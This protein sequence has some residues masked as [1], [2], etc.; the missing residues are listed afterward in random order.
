MVV[1]ISTYSFN[2]QHTGDPALSERYFRKGVQSLQVLNYVDALYYFSQAYKASPSSHY[3]ELSYLYL[4][5]SYALYSYAYGSRKGIFASIAF[6]NE[7]PF[8]YKVPRFIH[9]QREFIG[10]S[11]LL[12]QWYGTAKNIYAN[13]YGET[14]RVEYMI[15]FGYASSLEGSIEGYNYLKKL[16]Q[17]GVPR[18]YLDL[19]YMTM[20]FY[21]FNLGKYS[22]SVEYLSY[23]MNINTHL[24][25]DPHLLFR[26]GVSYYKLGDWRKALLYLELTA[27]NDPLDTY[28]DKTNFYLAII[29]LETN[30]FREAFVNIMNLIQDDRLFYSKLSQI[31]YSSLWYYEDFLNIYREKLGDYRVNLLKLAWLNIE[32]SYGDFPAL[33]IYYF[34]LKERVL[35]EEEKE[36][37]S[38]KKL[39]LNGFLHENEFFTFDKYVSRLREYLQRISP[40]SREGARF[41]SHIYDINESNY[42]KLFGN[43][44]GIEMLARSLV[45][46][47]SPRSEEVI[48]LLKDTTLRD[49]L[50]A[51]LLLLK[52]DIEKSTK[53][54][55]GS[56][57]KLKGDDRKE[58]Q[59]LLS[60]L[61]GDIKLLEEVASS[62]DFKKERFLHY[63]PTVFLKLA[64]GFFDRG[65]LKKSLE[66]YRK[67]VELK[68]TDEDY[69]WALFRIA[70]ISEKLG[71]SETLKWV[72][73]QTEGSDNIWSRSI[74]TLWEG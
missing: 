47:G 22:L 48:P 50:T 44:K 10:D 36:F 11:Y 18:D 54:L 38:L 31:L 13:L 20:G 39:S 43:P 4:G 56:L 72:V 55:E 32:D 17:Q 9:T 21:N 52:G 67:V 49:F 8:H 73:N 19:Y 34:S 58:A 7:Y 16:N 60:Y 68:G 63:A 57:E 37:L 53:L 46:L 71:D 65:N 5:K 3:G 25:K 51:K 61:K 28:K 74:R 23:A 6:L 69:W 14:E 12:L 24:R 42:L 30:N 15:K 40:F 62:V 27:R 66:Y 35:S 1:L 64:D 41:I 33:G 2:A 29:N 45:F 26:L 70:Y 59:L